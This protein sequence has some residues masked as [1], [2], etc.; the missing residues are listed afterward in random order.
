MDG[1]LRTY[2]RLE[3]HVIYLCNPAHRSSLTIVYVSILLIQEIV[4][5]SCRWRQHQGPYHLERF[6]GCLRR[7]VYPFVGLK[8]MSTEYGKGSVSCQPTSLL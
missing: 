1:T 6:R 2:Y 3:I 4:I 5:G 7:L 8:N